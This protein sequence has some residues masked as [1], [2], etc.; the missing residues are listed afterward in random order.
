MSISIKKTNFDPLVLPMSFFLV[1]QSLLLLINGDILNL[2]INLALQSLLLVLFLWWS[3]MR[4]G[5]C[6]SAPSFFLVSLYYWNT[7]W[8]FCHYF[9]LSPL[10]EYTG[11]VFHYGAAEIPKAIALIGLCQACTVIGVV[12]GYARQKRIYGKMKSFSGQDRNNVLAQHAPG[13]EFQGSALSR[14]LVLLALMIYFGLTLIY[15]IK[16]GTGFFHDKYSE[17]IY[18][19]QPEDNW[20]YRLYQST[21]FFSIL[22]IITSLAYAKKIDRIYLYMAFLALMLVQ[23]LLGSRIMPFIT[24]ITFLV[25]ADHFIQRQTW[26]RLLIFV[27]TLA[28]VSCV[29]SYAR[30]M[31]GL[32][33]N[34]FNLAA[35]G[36][37]VNL[38]GFFWDAQQGGIVARTMHFISE[39]GSIFYGRSI[40][41]SLVYL[42]PRFIVDGWG[43]HTG[44]TAPNDWIVLH[45]GDIP[46]GGG[47]GFSMVAEAYFNFGMLGC[48]MFLCIGWFLGKGYFRYIF[49]KD[50][51]ALLHV[52]YFS[53]VLTL[54]MH[55]I[56][57]TY[58]RYLVY[59]FLFIEMLRMADKH[60]CE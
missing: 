11:R 37:K 2:K 56:I 1:L 50:I 53:L 60:S 18:L 40:F 35:S 5:S 16:I 29:V 45:S 36:H 54:N 51:Y 14:R 30:S 48:L 22:L 41:D 10:F 15:V 47:L 12:L 21:K 31:V 17:A 24:I 19:I 8:F 7:V 55:T 9:Q 33:W 49:F 34:V 44:F 42:L 6:L 27:L 39:R 20:L 3:Y 25:G 58:M 4:S 13:Q 26:K 28:F 43:F 52:L 57:G 59:G 23:F 32:G 38:W 46:A